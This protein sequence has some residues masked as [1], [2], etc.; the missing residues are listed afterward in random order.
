M[1]AKGDWDHAIAE[2]DRA[3][4]LNPRIK[5]AHYNR[6]VAFSQKGDEARARADF[7]KEEQLYPGDASV[8]DYQET[9]PS[10]A[11]AEGQLPPVRSD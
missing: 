10:S 8:Q 3:I 2:F 7:D 5:D 1:G 6:G 11:K 4:Q 9:S